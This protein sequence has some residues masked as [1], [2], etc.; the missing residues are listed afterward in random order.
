M[1]HSKA[2]LMILAVVVVISGCVPT[3]MEKEV[4]APVAEN[5]GDRFTSSAPE[6]A[7]FKD[8]RVWSEKYRELSEDN[9]LLKKRNDELTTDNKRL[10]GRFDVFRANL[11]LAEKELSDANEMLI[12]MRKELDGWKTNVI[13]FREE[14]NYVHKEQLKALVKILKLLGAEYEDPTQEQQ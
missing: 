6:S 12:E 9:K 3:M 8:I 11:E 1:N 5:I 2:I 10:M 13:G 4:P 14:I 7:N